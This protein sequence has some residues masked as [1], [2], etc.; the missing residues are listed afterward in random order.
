MH[1][2]AMC[3]EAFL[4]L[5]TLDPD[6]RRNHQGR[7]VEDL[8][9]D[10][11]SSSESSD[12]YDSDSTSHPAQISQRERFEVMYG[13]LMRKPSDQDLVAM[14]KA[15]VRDEWFTNDGEVF[16]YREMREYH[17]RALSMCN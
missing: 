14:A 11:D 12:S 17:C 16:Y 2:E 8:S 10:S 7:Q 4:S 9:W 5:G 6:E 13:E 3:R 15:Q 1:Y